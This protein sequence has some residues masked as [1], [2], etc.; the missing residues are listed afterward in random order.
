[1]KSTEAVIVYRVGLWALM[2]MI[3]CIV[4][5]GDRV[6]LPSAERL[7]EFEAA[8]PQGPA[9]DM[10]RIVR[11]RMPLGPYRVVSGDVL[12]LQV[13]VTLYPD[14]SEADVA[15][16]AER[17]HTCRVSDAG[18][19]TLPDGRLAPVV[20][21]SLAEVESAVVEMYYPALVK[22][23]PAVFARVLEYRTGRLHIS[24]AVQRPGVYNLNR[25]QMSL[26]A[27]L[28]EAGGIIDEGAALIRIIRSP[29][30]S[31]KAAGASGPHRSQAT[32]GPRD[33]PRIRDAGSNRDDVA[34]QAT[35][36]SASRDVSIR[37]EPEGA[38]RTTGWL[39]L[40]EGQEV[41]VRQW[42]DIANA[43]QRWAVLSKA[44]VNVQGLPA[45]ALDE[46]LSELARALESDQDRS[47]VHLAAQGSHFGWQSTATGHFRASLP[48][49][50]LDEGARFTATTSIEGNP[51]AAA[52]APG[53]GDVILTLPVRGLNI[54]FADV[55][56][57]EGDAVV[58]ERLQTQ[59]I[60]VMGLVGR[61]GNYPYP[62]GAQYNLAQAVGFAGGL[63]MVAEPRYVTIYRLRA[64]GTV[65]D[66]TFQLIDT[67]NQEELTDRLAVAV[68]PGDIV[69]VE[70][71]PR[72]RSKVFFDRVFRITLG[73]YLRP[74]ELLNNSNTD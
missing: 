15:A 10:G 16:G 22:A 7:V 34:T 4:G 58:V 25:D 48:E 38:L 35:S 46:K 37:F 1:M 30:T 39:V 36:L 28:M 17:T 68:K 26:V 31:D 43:F 66:A 5:C 3:H 49:G 47:V 18:V 32:G 23:R 14:I 9:V 13:P 6:R 51:N 21:K 50:P 45:A 67:Q 54:P 69:A 8:G 44:A 55:P 24:G 12:Q 59:Y 56:L 33:V 60:S 70:H 19:I 61:P 73:L 27:L 64:N 63:D 40:E 72:T 41:R 71:T 29:S 20:G 62:P 2:A 74:E 42:F 65:V 57:R 11:A 52:A 53:N